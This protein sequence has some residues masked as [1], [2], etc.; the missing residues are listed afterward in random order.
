MIAFR[1]DARVPYEPS[2][3]VANADGTRVRKLP[4]LPYWPFSTPVVRIRGAT[5]SRR[6]RPPD[7]TYGRSAS[8]GSILSDSVS[9][10]N[11]S[12]LPREGT[13]E[14]R[15]SGAAAEI[16]RGRRL[17]HGP[18]TLDRPAG[19]DGFRLRESGG[20]DG[21]NRVVARRN[22]NRLRDGSTTAPGRRPQ[23]RALRALGPRRPKQGGRL[24]H[25]D[26][27]PDAAPAGRR[28]GRA[29]WCAPRIETSIPTSAVSEGRLFHRSERC[30]SRPRA[31]P[32][33]A[34]G[35]IRPPRRTCAARVLGLGSVRWRIRVRDS[36]GAVPPD[37]RW[38][39]QKAGLGARR[40]V[41]RRG[42]VGL[43]TRRP[44]HRAQQRCAGHALEAPP[45]EDDRRPDRRDP[46]H[47]HARPLGL[48]IVV[49]TLRRAQE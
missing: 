15:V 22:A 36:A 8:Q 14:R 43:V 38:A 3:Y 4:A 20:L 46:C 40:P 24:L 28:T 42:V 19:A 21:R 6:V 34:V 45:A 1:S 33:Q 47:P 32:R 27:G 39:H 30:G 10:R 31:R 12:C 7:R 23:A 13:P 48:G 29:C 26:R 44:L 9:R 17:D 25:V 16:D 5:G 11:Q 49:V 2:A 37:G 41:A 18:P 35:S